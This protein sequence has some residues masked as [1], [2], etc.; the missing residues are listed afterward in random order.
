MPELAPVTI[1]TLLFNTVMVCLSLNECADRQR[2]PSATSNHPF[3]DIQCQW[4]RQR[5]HPGYGRLKR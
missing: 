2:P 1:A 5:V 3:P 4:A